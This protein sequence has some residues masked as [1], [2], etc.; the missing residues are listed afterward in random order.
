MR[1]RLRWRTYGRHLRAGLRT[2]HGVRSVREGVVIQLETEGGD[3]GYGEAAPLP[4][5]GT[6]TL[7]VVL[8]RLGALG[9]EVTL[10]QL[11]EVQA[12]LPC[13]RFAVECAL[14]ELRGLRLLPPVRVDRLPVVAL[15][16]LW[17]PLDE[18]ILPLAEAGFRTLKGKVACES[19]GREIARIEAICHRLPEGIRLR[20]DANAGFTREEAATFLEETRDLPIEFLEQPIAADDLPG[21]AALS[22]RHP[23]RVAV[24]ESVRRPRDLALLARAGWMGPVVMKPSLLGTVVL[25]ADVWARYNWPWVFSSALETQVGA[26]HALGIAFALSRE[27]RAVGFGTGQWMPEDGLGGFC[28]GPEILW[29]DLVGWDS[30]SVWERLA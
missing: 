21:L 14:V 19:V 6:E 29:E 30:G 24:E 1:L 2:A 3:L 16:D 4:E 5:F 10:E 13:T 8:A 7:E 23:G 22:E 18:A 26:A 11:Q 25:W 20:L 12:D 15:V 9:E 17:R 27:A 28:Q